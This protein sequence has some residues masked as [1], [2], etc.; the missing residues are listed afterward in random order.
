MIWFLDASALVKRY[1]D[2]PGTAAVRG[3]VRKRARLAASA[4]SVVEVAGALWRRVRQGDI[5]RDLATRHAARVPADLAEMEVLEPRAPVLELAVSLLEHHPLRAYDAI[6]L[7]SALRLAR[8][9][10]H[11][12]T[13]VC[14]DGALCKIARAE[15]VRTMQIPAPA[16]AR[17]GIRRA[18]GRGPRA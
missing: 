16:R 13:F 7:A 8:A 12:V 4:I 11:A 18:R 14:A 1:V 2:E 17:G 3:L 15:Q 6:Q 10:G 9:T 5:D